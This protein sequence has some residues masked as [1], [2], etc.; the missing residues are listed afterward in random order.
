MKARI[1]RHIALLLILSFILQ[2]IVFPS[3]NRV[4]YAS[5]FIK[6]EE[7]RLS[8]TVL[9][10]EQITEEQIA[11]V[12]IMENL[13][14][15]DGIYEYRLNEHIVSQAYI[16][17]VTVGVTTTEAILEQLPAELDQY[18]IDWP[19]VIGKFAVGTSIIIA[20]G[21]INHVSHG[22]TFFVFGSPARIA[23]D[24]LIGGAIGAALTEV[25]NSL[26]SGTP[27]NKAIIKYAV[28]GFA[29]GYMWGAI[30]SVLRVAGSNYKR[31]RAFK[32]AT[33][34]NLRIKMDGSVLDDA[35]RIIGRALYGNDGIWYLVD[36]ATNS[37][38]VFNASG[39]ELPATAHTLPPN[40]TYRLGTG[41]NYS[42][43]RTDTN[44]IIYRV[45]DALQ[46]NIQYELNGYVYSTDS[47][48]RI[49]SVSFSDLQFKPAG[50]ARL[51]IDDSRY[52]IGHGNWRSTD[53]RGH[54]IADWFGG[55]NT[56][57]NIVP[58]AATVNKGQ[59]K[60]IETTFARALNNGQQV[61]GT[62]T[63]SYS[64]GSYRPAGFT[65]TYDI[66]EGL[67][68]IRIAN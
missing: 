55:D 13:I 48:G 47:L 41:D 52:A 65:Y 16:I 8:E 3:S 28:E 46:P 14:F 24:A 38:R 66:G 57:A 22:S 62:I 59:V 29:D 20:V 33:G 26:S 35:D 32:T 30:T 43:C 53:D 5:S 60:A 1:Q 23:K 50:R 25:I 42:L 49:E 64:G 27:V 21:V 12:Y 18:E 61:S 58:Q 44:G 45:D 2:L 51:D 40:N 34:G 36:D 31:L 37:I 7:G 6:I 68:T 54:L 39:V 67:V 10:E 4:A 63:V 17:E 19:A 15:E 9:A 56:M 11:P